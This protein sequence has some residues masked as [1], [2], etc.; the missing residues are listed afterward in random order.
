VAV[1]VREYV[2]IRRQGL[3]GGTG[4]A[5]EIGGPA[6]MV[7]GQQSVDYDSQRG[8]R[9]T[10]AHRRDY[11]CFLVAYAKGA[12]P[13]EAAVRVVIGA[14]VVEDTTTKEEMKRRACASRAWQR[15]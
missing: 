1:G 9:R 11:Y 12:E 4:L 6:K 14:G 10:G 8:M 5:H 2:S 13:I 15:N 7:K 3:V